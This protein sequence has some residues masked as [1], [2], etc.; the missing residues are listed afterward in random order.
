[1]NIACKQDWYRV[2]D[3]F[4][5]PTTYSLAEFRR[6]YDPEV[7]YTTQNRVTAGAPFFCERGSRMI[8]LIDDG[9]LAADYRIIE[10]VPPPGIDVVVQGEFD[11]VHGRLTFLN[12]PMRTA[13]MKSQ[14]HIDRTKLMGHVGQVYYQQLMDIVEMFPGHVVE[15]SIYTQPIGR[16]A[17][18]LIIWEV[19]NY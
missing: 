2:N 12:E 7:T 17:K 18:H 1:M 6:T 13:L 8:Q 9:T 10:C 14:I 15:F 5:G 11:G 3:L 16:L 19:R 4:N